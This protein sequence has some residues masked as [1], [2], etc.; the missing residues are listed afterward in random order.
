MIQKL[1][2]LF[3]GCQGRKGEREANGEKG[4][5]GGDVQTENDTL[6]QRI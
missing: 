1:T 6:K 2:I 4:R 3:H 5:R